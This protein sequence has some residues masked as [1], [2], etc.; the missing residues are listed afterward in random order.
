MIV[1]AIYDEDESVEFHDQGG[2]V[3]MSPQGDCAERL[4]SGE[5]DSWPAHWVAIGIGI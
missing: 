2:H 4:A 5:T 1:R 3:A